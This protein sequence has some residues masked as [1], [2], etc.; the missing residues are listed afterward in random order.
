MAAPS[1]TGPNADEEDIDIVGDHHGVIKCNNNSSTATGSSSGSGERSGERSGSA[2]GVGNRG[3]ELQLQVYGAVQ[4]T[5]ADVIACMRDE[6]G[7]DSGQ[8]PIDRVLFKREVS[9]QPASPVGSCGSSSGGSRGHKRAKCDPD[10]DDD[11]SQD[12]LGEGRVIK[13]S[14]IEEY[15][16]DLEENG[17][18][19]SAVGGNDEEIG[20]DDGSAAGEGQEVVRKLK[21]KLRKLRESQKCSKCMVS[22]GMPTFF[23][24]F[25]YESCVTWYKLFC[26]FFSRFCFI[27]MRTKKFEIHLRS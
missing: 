12:P 23:L 22:L 25:K 15:P 26:G 6:A 5:E 19:K 24:F 10:V 9:S 1:L 18:N 13:V 16:T 20:D 14:K 7:K 27:G 17:E 3:A 21:E 11:D 2:C 4:F 8:G